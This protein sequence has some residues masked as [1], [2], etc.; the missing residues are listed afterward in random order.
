M[1]DIMNNNMEVVE[2]EEEAG[3]KDA[4][5]DE[6]QQI[7]TRKRRRKLRSMLRKA[8]GF[9]SFVSLISP[10]ALDE[11]EEDDEEEEEEEP[12]SIVIDV[13]EYLGLHQTDNDEDNDEDDDQNH[14]AIQE[15]TQTTTPADEG[16]YEGRVPLASP[17]D[18]K[19]LSSLQQLIRN[20]LEIF[21]ATA[22]D[23]AGSQSGRRL[24]IVRGKV[25][26]RCIHCASVA[27]AHEAF[28]ANGGTHNKD[29]PIQPVEK[30]K[31][32]P[33]GAVSYPN[34]IAGMYSICSQKPQLHFEN[35]PNTPASVRSQFYRHTHETA[36]GGGEGRAKSKEVPAALYYLVA[37]KR[38]GLVDVE[39]G[40]RFSRDLSLQPL[41]FEAV[42]ASQRQES[43]ELKTIITLPPSVARSTAIKNEEPVPTLV[44]SAVTVSDATAEQV[45]A[46]ALAEP[47]NPTLYLGRATDKKMVSDYMFLCIRQVA[48]CH[49]T[50]ADFATRGKKTRKMR[51]GFAGFCCRHC[52]RFLDKRDG[53]ELARAL[54]G[55]VSDY[56]CRS[57]SSNS[58]GLASAIANTFAI[59]LAKCDHA[60]LKLRKALAAYKR[61]HPRQMA[62]MPH[63]S[64]RKAFSVIWERQRKFDVSEEQMRDKIAAYQRGQRN[65][66]WPPPQKQAEHHH[67]VR[68]SPR[69]TTTTTTSA[70]TPSSSSSKKSKSK[71]K[72]GTKVGRECSDFPLSNDPATRRTLDEYLDHWT[73]GEDNDGLFLPSDR[74]IA[75]DYIFLTVRQLKAAIPT[76]ADL[77]KGKRG[78]SNPIA[79]MCCM[80]C[81]GKDPSEIAPSCRSFATAPDNY[82]SAFNTSLY[83]HMQNC[84]FIKPHVK[85]ALADLRKLHSQQIQALQFGAQRKF[86]TNLYNRLRAVPLPGKLPQAPPP[87]VASSSSSSKPSRRSS[88]GSASGRRVTR[89]SESAEDA[90]LASYG[91]FEAP[92]QS[93]FCLRC[94]MVPLQFRARGSL[95]FAHPTIEFMTEHQ[96][97]CAED[98]MNLWYC[99]ESVKKLLKTEFS[100]KYLTDELFKEVI[101]ECFGRNE[102]LAT[103]FTSEIVKVYQM[104][105]HGG[106]TRSVE[107]YIKAKSQGLWSKLPLAVDSAKVTRAYATFAASVEGLSPRISDNS[108]LFTYLHLISP[109]LRLSEDDEEGAG[110]ESDGIAEGEGN[111]EEGK[112]ESDGEA[113]D[114]NEAVNNEEGDDDEEEEEEAEIE[115]DP[116]EEEE[117]STGNPPPKKR[118]KR[119]KE[120]RRKP[121]DGDGDEDAAGELSGESQETP[122][123]ET[124]DDSLAEVGDGEAGTDNPPVQ[125]QRA[126]TRPKRGKELRR[127][128]MD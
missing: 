79:G 52:Q 11:D 70:R 69:A 127:P 119:G 58:D 122:S 116:E 24:P 91:F 102:Q 68:T 105:R 10:D 107:N 62:D 83:N 98:G 42:L 104:S 30:S 110:S 27:L 37:A 16:Y 23:A 71:G 92:C 109:S 54:P 35:C 111:S 99:V 93:F 15:R 26:I 65:I 33:Q 47:E 43:E 55:G 78:P 1:A 8:G 44:G 97:A 66:V 128:D 108:A 32:Y 120:L 34:N 28:L 118:R 45:L 75:S 9:P 21:S 6:A 87:P 41:P 126:A 5:V 121:S 89:G 125:V 82:A 3:K 115:D 20:H 18:E 51:V 59:H 4:L 113:E 56:S 81:D 95:S 67:H 80:H 14:H 124:G 29:N 53:P 57:F 46:E 100:I 114:A 25:G 117:E 13:D 106:V 103:I 36:R 17:D 12:E 39:G 63:G 60:P 77:A 86:F 19:Y 72:P 40:I 50:P 90:I 112:A 22:V 84:Q 48:V 31:L 94:R 88:A 101:L 2:E 7:R 64:Q 123:A 73:P 96:E 76:T 74:D 49:A 38:H 85:K 61:I